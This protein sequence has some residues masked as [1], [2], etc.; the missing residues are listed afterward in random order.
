M[1]KESESGSVCSR[2]I[3]KKHEEQL[4][5]FDKNICMLC[6]RVFK[7]N[8]QIRRH[9][10]LSQLHSS[11]LKKLR[12]RV[13]TKD[14]IDRFERKEREALYRDRAR[15]RRLKIGQSERVIPIETNY[16]TPAGPIKPVSV[17]KP[18]GSDN[19]GAALLSKMG[20]KE[21]QG[22]GRSNE[23]MTDII[24]L[25]PQVGNAG[26]GSKTYKVDHHGLSYKEAVKKVMYQRYHE[27]SSE[28]ES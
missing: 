7:D 28:E 23:G 3:L 27:I 21:G 18:I 16:Q 13:F 9:R 25:D 8:D 10:S 5:D 2:L 24:R 6:K 4:I 14:Q 22:L 26:L 17:E 15:E 1:S 12:Q 20:W 19:K 11:R